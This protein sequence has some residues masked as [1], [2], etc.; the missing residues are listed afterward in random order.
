MR[1]RRI[2]CN[3][4]CVFFILT[5]PSARTRPPNVSCYFR[6]DMTLGLGYYSC[7]VLPEELARVAVHKGSCS[8]LV[9]ASDT[10]R[11]PRLRKGRSPVPSS[12]HITP[13]RTHRRERATG[14]NKGMAVSVCSF[15]TGTI[16]PFCLILR[17][18]SHK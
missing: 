7:E 3:I 8:S 4:R 5:R 12:I 6:L 11:V 13:I 17:A 16:A 2:L 18:H 15:G 1:E 9:R 10:S 14:G